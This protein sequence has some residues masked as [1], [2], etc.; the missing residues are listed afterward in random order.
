MRKGRQTPNSSTPCFNLSTLDR[1]LG[2]MIEHKTLLRES[3]NKFCR[4]WKMFGVDQ[5]VIGK[6]E[7]LQPCDALKKI[8]AQEEAIVRFRLHN[9]TDTYQFG[10]SGELAKLR[11]HV[12]RTQIYP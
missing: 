12:G 3:L 9:V 10:I 6:V 8:R 11:G 5:D 1:R 7:F 2:Q 4:H